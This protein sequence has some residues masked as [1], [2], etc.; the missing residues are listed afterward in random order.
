MMPNIVYLRQN[1]PTA[2]LN[3]HDVYLIKGLIHHGLPIGEIA[4]K[5]EVTKSCISRISNGKIWK[6]VPD[7]VEE[8]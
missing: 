1:H 4:E 7:Y 3:E 2:T 6:H 5:F 8:A